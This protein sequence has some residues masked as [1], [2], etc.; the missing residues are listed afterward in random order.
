[1]GFSP[2]KTR[3]APHAL[4]V[5]DKMFSWPSLA[6]NIDSESGSCLAISSQLAFL[7]NGFVAPCCLDT[8][9]DM[10]LGDISEQ[11]LDEIVNSKKAKNMREGFKRGEL[12]EMMCKTCGFREIRL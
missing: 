1:M 11:S 2:D 4:L 10:K 7:T 3:G 5:K 6:K 9:A 8:Q 12:I